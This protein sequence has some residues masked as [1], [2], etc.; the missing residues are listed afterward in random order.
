M[1]TVKSIIYY[2]TTADLTSIVT[3]IITVVNSRI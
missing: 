1:Y 2:L 3:V